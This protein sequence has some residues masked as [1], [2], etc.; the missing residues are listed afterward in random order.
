[1]TA[2]RGARATTAAAW[3]A[4]P[5]ARGLRVILG[6]VAVA[7]ALGVYWNGL[8]NPFVYDDHDTVLFNPSLV[9]LSNVRFIFLYS[10][11]RPA[12]NVSYAIDRAFW[13]FTPFGFH[14]TNMAL[15]AA[16]VALFFGVCTR[17]LADG[18]ASAAARLLR[19]KPAATRL[20]Q[21]GSLASRVEWPAFFAAALY[22]V[23]P[24]MTEAAGY[25]SGRSEVLCAAGFLGA[26]LCARTAIVRQSRLAAAGAVVSGAL[27]FASKETAIALPFVLI[28]YDAWVL[29]DG[30]WRRRLT[31]VYLPIVALL[32]VAGA[33]RLRTL[34]TA[35]PAVQRSPVDNLLTQAIVIWRY[36][37]LLILPT[38][39]TIMHHVR[40]VTTAADPIALAALAALAAAAFVAIRQRTRAPLLAF[41]VAWF[42][43]VLA[44]SS[45]VV[46]LR[47]GMAEHRVYLASAGLFLAAAALLARPLAEQVSARAMGAVILAVCAVLTLQRNRVWADPLALWAEAAAQAPGMWEPHY[48][49]ADVLREAGQCARAVPEY[50]AVLRLRPNHRDAQTNLG[51]CLAETGRPREAERAFRRAIDI[52]PQWARGYT[53]LGALAI[54]EKSYDAARGFYLDALRCDPRNVLARMQLAH[55]YESVFHDYRAAAVM[56]GEARAIAPSTPGVVECA[57]RNWRLAAAA[58]R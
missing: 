27:A 18:S 54:T 47:E 19:D 6:V 40:F 21:D 7:L 48:A 12:V 58:G 44:P 13:G 25:V 41:G 49:Y 50:E 17:A 38:G 53:N 39:Q 55:L 23:H 51:I 45:S 11:F 31:R 34:W 2:Q 22:A 57:E 15:H 28:A 37:G 16:V 36:L 5:S 52:D 46:P 30:N 10:L 29:G 43:L 56:C 8:D 3:A 26:M 42:L 32:L 24:M 33:V 20:G 35:A 14:I 1:M 9:D 4:R